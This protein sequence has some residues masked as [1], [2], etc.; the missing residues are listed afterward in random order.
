MDIKRH[1]LKTLC[2]RA[3]IDFK[4]QAVSVTIDG[5]TQGIIEG[6]IDLIRVAGTRSNVTVEFCSRV[7][8]SFSV[9]I[10]HHITHDVS[11]LL[12]GGVVGSAFSNVE[13][14][15]CS[16]NYNDLE[17]SNIWLLEVM[18]EIMATV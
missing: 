8:D 2:K 9:R 15:S 16:L 14:R 6:H 10:F 18:E 1:T 5:E 11:K 3:L 12:A 13:L 4:A 17:Q 7:G